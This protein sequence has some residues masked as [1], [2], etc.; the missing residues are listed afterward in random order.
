MAKLK[1]TPIERASIIAIKSKYSPMQKSATAKLH[2]RNLGTVIRKRE[3]ISTRRTAKLPKSAKTV[4]IQTWIRS[5]QFPII[6]SQGLKASGTGR[7]VTFLYFFDRFPQTAYNGVT[8]ASLNPTIIFS[9]R[10]R[11]GGDTV[12]KLTQI[13]NLVKFFF[14]HGF[15][16]IKR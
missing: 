13:N 4:T 9:F 1:Y 15:Y 2:M 12:R 14:S 10:S 5:A 3:L 7:Q 11:G 8:V 6:S 16:V